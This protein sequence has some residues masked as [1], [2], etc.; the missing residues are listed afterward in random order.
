LPPIDTKRREAEI[1]T[2][3]RDLPALPAVLQKLIVVL[4]DMGSSTRDIQDI[5]STDPALTAK[6]LRL[7]NS[8]LYKGAHGA[9][10]ISQAVTRLGFWKLRDVAISVGATETLAGLADPRV[11]ERFWSHAIYTA[12]CAHVLTQ[13]SGT[14]CSEETFVVGLLHD[15]GE[16]V[17]AAIMPE[18]YAEY[19]N[20]DPEYRLGS[21]EHVFGVTH[22]RVGNMLLRQWDLPKTLC[23]AVRLHHNEIV[24]RSKREPVITVVAAADLLS[25]LH[26]VGGEA[27]CPPSLLFTLFK[28]MKIEVSQ[29][30]AILEAVDKRVI[31]TQEHLEITGDLSIIPPAGKPMNHKVAVISSDDTLVT[32]YR[33]L[34]S[35]G[36]H[37]FQA[38][39][40]FLD[41]PDAV[42]LVILD[43]QTLGETRLQRLRP[44]LEAARHK[45]VALVPDP[46]GSAPLLTDWDLPKIDLFP[47][48]D[49]ITQTVVAAKRG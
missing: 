39:K 31:E 21:E 40:P 44:V 33:Q 19:R 32:W 20:Y 41:D 1:A 9:A 38:P 24:I 25:R 8:P 23:E 6:I 43:L 45:T 12:T 42:D 37:L 4:N 17:L 26:G 49:R 15:I 29:V 27:P 2:R 18:E 10:T 7:A 5:I 47:S 11:Q 48:G 16:L 35:Y 13:H 34:L 3:V 46:D 36:G 22:A 14:S 30:G 28:R